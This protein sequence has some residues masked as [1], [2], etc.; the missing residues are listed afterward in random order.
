[1]RNIRSVL[2]GLILISICTVTLILSYSHRTLAYD[3]FQSIQSSTCNNNGSGVT[4]E[5]PLCSQKSKDNPIAGPGGLI[6]N[7]VNVIAIV[8]GVAAVIVI[9]FG[10][11]KYVTSGGDPQKTASAKNTILYAVIGLVLAVLAETI[12]R[13]TISKVP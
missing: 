3:P 7:L 13:F 12:V 6:N 1:M 10:G 2:P 9:I 4:Q 8:I 11:F 5:S